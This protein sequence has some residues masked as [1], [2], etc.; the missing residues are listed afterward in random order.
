M[1]FRNIWLIRQA[2]QSRGYNG[3]TIPPKSIW[4]KRS[5]GAPMIQSG[6]R[7]PAGLGRPKIAIYWVDIINSPAHSMQRQL[8]VV[9]RDVNNL[10]INVTVRRPGWPSWLGDRVFS[11]DQ[12]VGWHAWVYRPD[13]RP[14]PQTRHNM[15][16]HVGPNHVR[17]NKTESE[18]SQAFFAPFV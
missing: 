5:V 11:W 18:K 3:R 7:A 14:Y 9:R 15:L 4:E 6:L 2:L 10:D 17:A 12:L 8:P 13:H 16:G 1:E